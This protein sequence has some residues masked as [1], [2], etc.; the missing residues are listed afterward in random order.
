VSPAA[1][2]PADALERLE[3][4]DADPHHIPAAR[5]ALEE[6]LVVQLRTVAQGLLADQLLRGVQPDDDQWWYQYASLREPLAPP[7]DGGLM[8]ALEQIGERTFQ[9]LP[10][11]PWTDA[12]VLFHTS[13]ESLSQ[14]F[15]KRAFAANREDP[16]FQA[17]RKS[18]ALDTALRRVGAV[19]PSAAQQIRVRIYGGDVDLWQEGRINRQLRDLGSSFRYWI[20]GGRRHRIAQSRAAIGESPSGAAELPCFLFGDAAPVSAIG[21][22][23]LLDFEREF[24]VSPYLKISIGY[25]EGTTAV[26]RRVVPQRL[27]ID[28]P[29][30]EL[31]HAMTHDDQSS[32]LRS[33]HAV[34]R[35][36]ICRYCRTPRSLGNIAFQ[37]SRAF[38]F[39]MPW[40]VAMSHGP[41]SRKAIR[42]DGF[43]PGES[44][45]ELPLHVIVQKLCEHEL[46]V[47][48]DGK[49]YCPLFEEGLRWHL[50]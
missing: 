5:Q 41:M 40:A 26:I 10:A 49:Y 22:A 19:A 27:P 39:D 4:Q 17:F 42:G 43:P 31:Y 7:P 29:G 33:W 23:A 47:L 38:G 36:D 15:M 32:A 35:D 3:A 21:F 2:F 45:D 46:L 1:T 34:L 13:R 12:F 25:A 44:P 24:A 14:V 8:A 37:F 30:H 6:A 28:P 20:D 11:L 50:A 18:F 48:Q 16:A 9:L